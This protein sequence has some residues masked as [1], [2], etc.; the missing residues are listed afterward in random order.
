MRSGHFT[1]ITC[2]LNFVFFMLKCEIHVHVH[3]V[4]IS[5]LPWSEK[6]IWKRNFFLVMEKS[7]SGKFGKDLKSQRKVRN[8]KS[9]S[10]AV[11]KNILILFKRKGHFLMR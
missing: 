10:T 9:S 7:W 6:N 5:G 3:I 4:T 2:S 1:N 11:V 8:L